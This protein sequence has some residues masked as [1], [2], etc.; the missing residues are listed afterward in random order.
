M[1]F[2]RF[3]YYL[4]LV[5]LIFISVISIIHI[6]SIEVQIAGILIAIITIIM[7]IYFKLE[8]R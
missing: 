6:I 5:I 7:A 8:E 1:S 3:L 4:G 2:S